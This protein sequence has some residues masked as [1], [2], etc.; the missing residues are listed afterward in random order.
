MKQRKL[1]L[2]I[3]MLGLGALRCGSDDSASQPK[4]DA[5]T[6]G[7][8]TGGSAGTSGSAGVGGGGG[9]GGSGGGTFQDAPTESVTFQ[10]S[11]EDFP[12]PE[13][14]FFRNIDVA[15]NTDFTSIS[16]GGYTL[17]RSYIRL[18]D[19]R[20]QNLPASLLTALENGF[21]G[22][23]KAGIKVIPRCAYNFGA[24]PDAPKSWILTHIGQLAPVLQKN[25]DVIAAMETG[26]IGAWGEWHSSTNG[27]DNPADRKEIVEGLLAALPPTRMVMLRTPRYVSDMYATPLSPSQAYDQSI[28]ARIGLHNDCFLSNATDAGTY[29]PAP[30]EDHKKYLEAFSRYTPVGGETCQV[31][32]SE[33]RTDCTT[34]LAELERFHFSMLNLDFYKGDIDRWKSEGCFDE[35]S[36]RFGYRLVLATAALPKRVRPGGRFVLQVELSNEGFGALYNPRPLRIVLEGQGRREVVDVSDDPRQWAPGVASKL[37]AHLELPADLPAGA[38]ELRLWLPD[39]ADPLQSRP[40][41]SVRFANTAVWDATA[42][43]NTL[44][45]VEVDATA[46][47][48]ANSAATKL[49]VVP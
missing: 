46:P 20:T 30:A 34:A 9:T 16:N 48:D 42:G 31:S 1:A 49:S 35:I 23:R 3:A 44:G 14:G 39:A 10:S 37:T 8:A 2:A 19:Y 13:R 47:G 18:D 29:V 5:G 28:Q 36:R 12:N 27:L 38:Y 26:F 17:A 45:S 11:M 25:A 32:L 40:E 24:D 43:E 21:A 7:A 15:K 6:G 33:H 41:Y 4:G 22:A